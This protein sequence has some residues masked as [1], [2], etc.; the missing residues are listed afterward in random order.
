MASDPTTRLSLS[1][2]KLLNTKD[3]TPE[4][5]KMN[6]NGR[7]PALYPLH[8]K[9]KHLDVTVDD[10]ERHP[11]YEWMFFQMSSQGPYFSQAFRFIFHHA[12]KIPTVYRMDVL[13]VFGVPE[14]VLSM[15]ECV[16]SEKITIVAICFVPWNNIVVRLHGEDVK[17]EAE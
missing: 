8:D 5:L 13:R 17:F 10:P 2:P 12:E 11:H 7:M 1:T 6:P 16:V 14:P 9:S 15:Q 3:R 4:Y